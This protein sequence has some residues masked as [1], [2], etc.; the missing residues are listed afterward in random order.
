MSQPDSK[1]SIF[2]HETA[3]VDEGAHIG[4]NTKVWHFSHVSSGS[5]IGEGCTL[6]QNVYVASG[7]VIGDRCKIQ[8]NVSLYEGVCLEDEVF[9]GPS[10]VFTNDF[11][12]RAQPSQGWEISATLVKKGA[13]IGANATIVCG[14]TIGEFAMVAAGA[15]VAQDVCDYALVVGVPAKQIGWVCSCGRKLN[16]QED[17]SYLCPLCEKRFEF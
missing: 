14:N 3:V 17:K 10:C 7:V 13:S 9:C 1:S 4:S 5:R 2:V 6:G 12:P 11:Y 8:N 15:V 16:K